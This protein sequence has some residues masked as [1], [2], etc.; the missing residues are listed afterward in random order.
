MGS[1]ETTKVKYEE[2]EFSE[3]ELVKI[4]RKKGTIAASRKKAR[5]MVKSLEKLHEIDYDKAM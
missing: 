2:D 1:Q 5:D 3:E 4:G